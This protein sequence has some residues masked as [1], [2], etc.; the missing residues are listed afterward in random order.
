MPC[1]VK[2]SSH[3][4]LRN[5]KKNTQ[6]FSIVSLPTDSAIVDHI[7]NKFVIFPMMSFAL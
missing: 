1:Q 7:Q 3:Y 6:D 5:K 2:T 4:Q